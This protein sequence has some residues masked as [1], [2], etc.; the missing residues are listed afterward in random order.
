M[1]FPRLPMAGDGHFLRPARATQM[2]RTARMRSIDTIP[3]AGAR[4]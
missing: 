4:L 1:T 2:S 3:D